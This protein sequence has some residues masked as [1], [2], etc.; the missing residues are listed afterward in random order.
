MRSEAARVRDIA[1]WVGRATALANRHPAPGGQPPGTRIT[2]LRDSEAARPSGGP[3]VRKAKKEAVKVVA[4]A[5]RDSGAASSDAV[6]C[7][8]TPTRYEPQRV[9]PGE[10]VRRNAAAAKVI[11]AARASQDGDELRLQDWLECR[12]AGKRPATSAS[13]RWQALRARLAA[14]SRPCGC[15]ILGPPCAC[16][17][18]SGFRE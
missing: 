12:P 17:S 5:G 11:A 1:C 10:E 2:Y 9:R 13:Q 8:P 14:K 16:A 3:A 4:L 6:D 18:S 15:R 7:H